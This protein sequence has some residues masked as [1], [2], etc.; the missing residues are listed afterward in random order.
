MNTFQRFAL[1]SF[2]ITSQLAFA[3]VKIQ[4]IL[5]RKQGDDI[6]VR[7]VTTNPARLSQKGPVRVN[8]FVR[9]DPDSPWRLVKN[10][11]IVKIKPGEKVSRDVF[12]ENSVALRNA[13]ENYNWQAKATVT[14]PG[15]RN[16][17]KTVTNVG[18]TETGK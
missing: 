15:A 16:G 5:L 17:E 6:N 8:L 11:S 14:A 12:A 13:A 9:A 2:I 7:V 3:D 4:D 18:D 10:W 1:T